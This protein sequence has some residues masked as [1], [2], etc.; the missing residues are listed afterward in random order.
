MSRAAA[1]SILVPSDPSLL[2]RLRADSARAAPRPV[3]SLLLL[4]DGS[5]SM[6]GGPWTALRAAV[7][8][9]AGASSPSRCHMAVAIW[10]CQADVVLPFTPDM[11]AVADGMPGRPPGGSTAMREALEMAGGLTWPTSIRRVVLLSDGVPTTGDPV[12]AARRLGRDGTTIDTV[13]CGP[14]GD[15]VLRAVAAA[16][17]GRHVRCSDVS[18]LA[19]VFRSLETGVR[20][21]LGAARST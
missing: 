4:L 17:G 16:G 2:G 12:P 21:L 20:G 13:A 18:E 10:A 3:E 14:H 8:S 5:S 1:A 11:Q 19:G 15:V 7:R 9:L 6:D